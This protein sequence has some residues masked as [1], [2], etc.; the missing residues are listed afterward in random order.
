MASLMSRNRNFVLSVLVGGLVCSSC[1]SFGVRAMWAQESGA[2]LRQG[3]A[4]PPKPARLR[5]YWWWLNGDTT[6]ATITSDLEA[7][8]AKG[9]GGALLVDADGSNQEGN[10]EVPAGPLFG[11]PAWVKLYVHALKEAKRLGLEISFN[12]TSGW[13][14]GGPSVTPEDGSKIL[15]WTRQIAIAGPEQLLKTPEAKNGFYRQIAVLAYPLKHGEALPGRG[16]DRAAIQNLRFK[17]ASAETGFS[18]EDRHLLSDVPAVP[19]EQDTELAKVVDVSAQVGPDSV[20]RWS[21]P[22][23]TG[24]WEILR[25]GYTDS[26]AMPQSKVLCSLP[27]GRVSTASGTWDGLAIDYMDHEAFDRFWDSV[28]K[29]LMAV[30]K[31]YLG[32]SLKYLVTDSWELNGT[33]WTGRFREEF[34]RRRGY[35]PVPYLPVVAGRIVGSRE[36]SDKFLADL[37]RTVGDLVVAEHYDVFAAHAQAYGLGIH[38]ESGGPHGAPL[39]A[40][41]TW[42]HAAFPQTEFWA[43]NPHRP[44]DPQRFFTKEAASAANIYG[45]PYVAQEGLTSM[46]PQW[47]ESLGKDLKPSF[48]QGITEGMTRLVWHQFTSSPASAGL[49]GNEYFA[50]TH[51]NPQV[52]WWAQA[53]DFLKYLNRCQFLMQQGYAVSDVLYYYG[54]QVP[55]FVRLKA[56]DPAKALPGFDYDV[57]DEDALLHSLKFGGGAVMTPTGNRYAA[58]VLPKTRNLTLPVLEKL[59]AYVRD[60]GLL[61]GMPPTGS[62]GIVDAAVASKVAVL[63]TELFGACGTEASAAAHGVGKGKVICTGDSHAALTALGVRQD[64]V[65]EPVAPIVGE[66]PLDYAHRRTSEGDIYF[67]RN[68]NGYAVKEK[69]TFR[70]TGST[71]QLWDAVTGSVHGVTSTAAAGTTTIPLELPAFGSTFVM[72][73]HGAAKVPVERKSVAVPVTLGS[74]WSVSFEAGRGAPASM[75][76]TE[77]TDWAQNADPGIRYFSGTATY[78]N[79]FSLASVPAGG[80]TVALSDLHEIATVRVNGASAGTIWALPYRLAIPAG[81]LHA[82]TNSIELQVTNLWPN[83]IIGD[84]QPGVKTPITHT[85]I[86]KYTAQSPLLPSGLIGP[87]TLTLNET[88]QPET[89]QH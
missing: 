20:L 80:L 54:D 44:T 60:G 77:L 41:E 6:E 16:S 34:K 56:D 2:T 86:R 22:A 19:G 58:V 70:V 31:P 14:L 83:R 12:I 81:L 78:R 52:T 25:I 76:M 50:G 29:P 48:D 7:M 61:I 62:T 18:M 39:D 4:T 30:S 42:R 38:P 85:N 8:A 36:L 37:R 15:T 66:Q 11:S 45:K 55:N 71:P 32:T 69:A 87:V 68:P 84:L 64:F 13:N 9:Y 59:Q 73:L 74:K 67:V 28:V 5:C 88:T 53:D 43:E 33:N 24:Q 35:D 17:T 40:L 65:S 51:L 27:C 21:P 57:T 79:E 49:P 1:A 3:F 10:Q 75:T 47:S 26:A 46:G 72:F 63:T 82:G 89:T 23:G